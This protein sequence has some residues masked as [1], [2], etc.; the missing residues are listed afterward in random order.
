MR[1]SAHTYGPLRHPRRPSLTLTSRRLIQL[2]SPL[3]LPVL[4]LVPLACMPSPIPRQDRW[5]CSLNLFIGGGLPRSHGGSAPALC[6]SRPAQ[7]SLAL[8]PACSPSRHATLFTGGFNSFV[9]F[10]AAPIVTG[11]SE[12]A[13]GRD[14]HP[15]WTSAFPRRTQDV[16]TTRWGNRL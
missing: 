4:R 2:R 8:R 12:P 9:T 7:R 11:R 6:V 16:S 15:L 3:G 10:T 14:F 5:T 13:P 1:C